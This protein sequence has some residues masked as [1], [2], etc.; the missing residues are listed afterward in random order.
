MPDL[1][2]TPTYPGG[3]ILLTLGQHQVGAVFPPCSTER[4]GQPWLWRWWLGGPTATRE[5]RA[6]T[7]EAAKTAILGV[8]RDWLRKAGL[9]G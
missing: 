8:A 9:D 7:E 2:F 5:G 4:H 3:R 6:K 1:T